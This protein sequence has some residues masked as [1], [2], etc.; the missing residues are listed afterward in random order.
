MTLDSFALKNRIIKSISV[1]ELFRVMG[2]S[3]V[4]IFLPVYMLL[5]FSNPYIYIVLG[6]VIPSLI[7]PFINLFGGNLIDKYGRRRLALLIPFF[8][9]FIFLFLFFAIRYSLSIAFLEIPFIAIGP[10]ASLQATVDNVII[11][12]VT[13]ESERLDSF[14]YI[15]IAANIGFS[16]GPT[17][18]GLSIAINYDYLPVIP[19]LAEIITF[20]I[21]Y[22]NIKETLAQHLQNSEKPLISFPKDDKKFIFTAILVSL[23]F[24]SLG[25]WGYILAQFLSKG[26]GINS[27]LVGL[28][29]ATNGIVVSV[30]QIPTNRIFKGFTDGE[31][32]AIGL[33][34]YSI[35]FFVI[36]L[37]KNYFILLLD[38]AVL[39]I[40]ENVISPSTL[41][42]ISKISPPDRRGE[43]FGSY[44]LLNSLFSPIAP[45]FYESLLFKFLNFPFLLWSIVA[46]LPFLTAIPFI[47]F[48]RRV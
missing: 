14:S 9:F 7:E 38:I 40:G 23:S 48:L 19:M 43:Y 16:L 15:R 34:I 11:S 12:D 4:W 5:R 32:I 28:L 47:I 21:Y 42:L 10:L 39:T 37:T 45:L 44:S 3:G 17:L 22:I 41:T 36:G 30:F 20:I 24:F 1:A 29:F 6:F 33:I 27:F 13:H 26:Y 8:N 18:A 25:A 46:V 2:R 31:K 35:T